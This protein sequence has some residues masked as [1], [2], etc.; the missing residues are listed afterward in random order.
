MTPA[1]RRRP[2]AA[3]AGALLLAA[4][5]LAAGC[6]REAPT[7]EP[8]RLTVESAP[9]GAAILIDGQDTGEITPHTFAPLDAGLYQ[10]SVVLDGWV[11][12]PEGETVDLKPLDD[13]TV[14]FTLSQTGLVITSEPA[15]A[16]ILIDGRD[17]G[18]VTPAT[19]AGLEPG[20]VEVA[21]EL[22]T[23]HVFPAGYTAT[24]TDGEVTELPAGT[25]TLR[26]R[27]TVMLEGFANIDCGPCPQLTDNLLALTS[28]PGYGPDRVLFVEFAVNWPNGQDPF[29][30][31]NPTENYDRFFFYLVA[32]APTLAADGVKLADAVDQQLLRTAVDAALAQDPG[33]LIDVEADLEQTSIPVTVTLWPLRDLDLAGHELFVALYENEIVIDPAPGSNGQTE[34]HHVFRDRVD[35]PPTLGGL[36]AD[37]P[38]EINVTLARGDRLP[39]NLTV[40]AFIQ[41]PS[42]RVVLQ[43]G[44]TVGVAKP[45]DL[46]TTATE[47]PRP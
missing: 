7:F 5:L 41:D 33:V 11:A 37:V 43:A 42:T 12:S 14:A 21:L 39:E 30:L 23:F 13:R 6:G 34:F 22:D 19:V 40:I 28:Q 10:V 2:C 27:R 3:G 20:A 45:R 26:S 25:F 9:A 1:S 17:T 18:Q 8:G 31:A 36:T 47:G 16:R 4:L 44:S 24:V 15:G 38:Q 32:T 35:T 46:V 29:Y